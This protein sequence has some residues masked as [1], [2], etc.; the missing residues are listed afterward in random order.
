MAEDYYR[1]LGVERTASPEEI[2]RAYRRL[3]HQHHPDKT[4]GDEEQFKKISAA[5][6][7][8]GDEG[9]RTQY[10]RFGTT[11]DQAPGGAGAGDFGGFNVHF[12]DIDG[13]GDIFEQFFGGS[14]QGTERQVRRGDDVQIDVTISFIESAQGGA[15]E[16]TTRLYQSCAHCR[17]SGAEPGTPIVDCATCG[18]QGTVSH[19]RQTM[20]GAFRQR[21]VCSTCRGE[22]KQAKTACRD[23]RGD[24]RQLTNR[25]LDI[26]IP[27]G[28]AD[29]QVIRL[30]GKGAVPVRGGIAGDLY[31]AI[32]VEPHPQLTR[33]GQF[34]RSTVTISFAEAALGVTK[35]VPTLTGEHELVI[36]AGTQPH[37]EV[38]LSGRGFPQLSGGRV[39]DQVVTVRVEIPRKLTRAQRQLLEQFGSLKR[40]RR[41]F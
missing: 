40:T 22:G 21:V 10:D 32:H 28:I 9:K 15:R 30:T 6:G 16:V 14:R 39:G 24:G 2:K 36:P 5:Y 8:L 26:S 29:G 35:Q 31:V 13:V 19:T 12:E 18:G 3:A 7:V 17:G 37:A 1:V 38:T 41:L 34:V 25:T 33:D 20:L 11:F 23:C 4:G 27:A